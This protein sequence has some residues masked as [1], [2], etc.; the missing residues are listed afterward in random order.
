M[1][2]MNRMHAEAEIRLHLDALLNKPPPAT[3]VER[4]ARL[5]D[6]ETVGNALREYFVGLELAQ[7]EAAKKEARP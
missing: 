1:S 6:W 4:A 3:E 7:K 2:T 5:D